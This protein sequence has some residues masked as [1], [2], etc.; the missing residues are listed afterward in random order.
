MSLTTII[1][2]IVVFLL[3]LMALK[4]SI[5]ILWLGV[6]LF[7]ILTGMSMITGDLFFVLKHFGLDGLAY[8]FER[9]LQIMGSF[10]QNILSHISIF[11]E[12]LVDMF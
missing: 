12:S 2:A 8:A 9:F 1:L 4:C 7:V 6:V 5:K 11:W 3:F 10:T